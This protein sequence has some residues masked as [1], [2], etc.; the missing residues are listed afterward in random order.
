MSGALRSVTDEDAQR[1]AAIASWLAGFPAAT[2]RRSMASALRAIV[3]AFEDLDRRA[4]VNVEL[5]A[6]EAL[7]LPEF[8]ETAEQ[9]LVNRYGREQ[10]VK[11][12]LA[13]RSLLR[14]LALRGVADFE[15][16]MQVLEGTKVHRLSSDPKSLAFDAADL[17]RILQCCRY[18]ASATAGLRD[19]AMI[20]LAATT[21]A[22]RRE[23][24]GIA[25]A[26]LDLERGE[27]QLHVKGGGRRVAVLH[28]ATADHLRRWI[29]VRGDEDGPLFPGLRRGGHL[30]AVAVSDH[31]FWKRL[32]SRSEEVGLDPPIAPHDLRRWFVTSL[33][34]SG[35]DVFQVARLVGHARVQTTL[36]YDRRPLQRM[37][38]VVDRL[39]IPLF[40]ELDREELIRE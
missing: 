36:R 15:L 28:R 19:L 5:F 32:R 13:M 7:D 14:H 11:Y 34:D 35:V 40:E 16:A 17:F 33:L 39:G 20:S 10:S 31:Q 22:R 27:V 29:A 2:S 18:D 1:A 21:G 26:D 24:V 25:M 3:R 38:E 30:T 6:W 8:F 4:P 12:V 37:R 23:L 9:R